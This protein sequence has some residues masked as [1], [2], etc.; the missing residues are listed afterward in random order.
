M[1]AVAP[2]CAL[3][4]SGGDG[5]LIG[6][7]VGFGR[8]LARPASASARRSAVVRRL[9]GRRRGVGVGGRGRVG[10]AVG[11]ASALE[12][13]VGRRVRGRVRG[14]ASRPGSRSASTVGFEVGFAVGFGS[15]VGFGCRRLRAARWRRAATRRLARRL[16]SRPAPGALRSGPTTGPAL[17]GGEAGALGEAIAPDG[18][19]PG[20]SWR[21]GDDGTIGGGVGP[22]AVVVWLGVVPVAAGEPTAVPGVDTPADPVRSGQIG[23]ADRQRDRDQEHVDD[24]ERDDSA[25]ALG[26]RHFDALLRG[27]A[28]PRGMAP[29]LGW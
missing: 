6:L 23:H 5:N 17:G 24:A 28:A 7:N 15:G 10:V 12:V 21:P 1:A 18:E 25:E 16:G 29:C 4:R 11:S 13:G 8:R 19:L 27:R 3:H 2:M 26:G 14:R 9:G 20:S 22:L